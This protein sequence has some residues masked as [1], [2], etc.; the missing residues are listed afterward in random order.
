MVSHGQSYASNG[1]AIRTQAI[2]KALSGH[3]FEALCFVRPGRPWELGTDKGAVDTQEI[4][5]GVRYIHSRWPDDQ[6]PRGE[7]NTLKAS[8]ERFVELFRIYRPEAVLAAS[9]YI[10]GL[11]AWI[12]ARRLGLPFYNEVRGFWELSRAAREPGYE[13]T[14]AFNVEAARDAFVGRQALKVFTLNQPMKEELAR[15]GVDADKIEIV[16]NG[17]SKLPEIK[18]T[19][20]A[21]RQ[22]LE[23]EA[24]D[25][26]VGYVGSFT[27]Y[28]GL[29]VLLDAC[30]ELVNQGEKIK[31]L[32]VGDGQPVTK[33]SGS[34][35]TLVDKPWLIQVGRVPHEQVADYY[36]L[37]D[38]VVI[39][40]KKLPVCE[41]VPPM[42]AAEAL[43]YGK[44]LVVSDVAA[45]GGIAAKHEGVVTFDAGRADSLAF[46]IQKVLSTAA[47]S[48]STAL[49][50]QDSINS[51]AWA[52]P[53]ESS[54][55]TECNVAL[56]EAKVPTTKELPIAAPQ[57]KLKKAPK[58]FKA[59][60]IMDEISEECWKYE[61]NSFRVDR[62]NYKSQVKSSTATFAFLESCWKGNGGAWEYAFTSPG[63]KHA[64]AQ[65]L[66]DLIPRVKEKMPVVFWNKEDPM[67]YERYLPIAKQADIIFTT[68]SNK[69]SSYEQDVPSADVY[70]VPFAAQQQICNPSDRFRTEP[71]T[72]CFAGSYYGVGHDERKRQMDALLPSIL[73][74]NGAIYDRFSKI[75]SDRYKFPEKFQPFIRD[76]VPFHE[77][78]K[79]YKRFKV[80]LN[81]NTIV[82][83]PTMMSRRV[84]ELLAC[85]TPVVSTPS[86]AIEE[87]FS[88]IVHMANDAQE[89]NKI[90]ERLLTDEHYWERTSH[91]GYR[92]VMTRHTYVHR[93]QSIKQ[94]LGYEAEDEEP[95]VSIITCTRRPNM[96]DRIVENMTRQNHS[97][98]ELI[99]VL[100]DF[101]SAQKDDLLGKLKAK[102]SNLKRIEVIVN[103]SQ[104]ITL[105]ERFNHAATY[106]KGEYIAKMDDD[107]FYFENYLSDMLIPFKFGNYGMVGKQELYMYLSGSNKLIKRFP[108]MKHREV[109]FVAGPTFVIKKS[110]FDKIKFESRNTGED[111]TFIKNLKSA[112]YKIYAADP[113]NFIQYRGSGGAHTWKVDD[114]FFLN[115]K[116][117][118]VI[119]D[120]FAQA[121]VDF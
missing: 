114:D 103:D 120:G 45:L 107:D 13:N 102:S 5:D 117:T 33:V 32:W 4:V 36:A 113:F 69:V 81:V 79:L 99:L 75:D 23:I 112:G 52:L 35:K 95:L 48:A 108:S 24:D 41:L 16:P 90:I 64:N 106:A 19:F 51:L 97:N 1:Y 54:V 9:N 46:S 68:D 67:H 70:A 42:K 85:G 55:V 56:P 58:D 93:L 82:D 86:K 11:P 101:S 47:P 57:K 10:V 110:V 72:V 18:H 105:G 39:P 116:Q 62:K 6:H 8:V 104:D 44:R 50:M 96:I 118:Q 40:R 84:Y 83:S 20:P 7:L 87:Q 34:S 53:G 91:L 92:E 109:D 63:L 14:P 80:F 89:A 100:Q 25:K 119:S 3:G 88:G 71:E 98:C 17:V 111:S 74:F 73:D 94:A 38:I 65:A 28:E 31:L 37:I 27:P 43:A 59:I 66:L 76:A 115:G 15:R 22:R 2:A 21:L 60:S 29:D 78:V 26:V 121:Y 61:F 12:A 49:L 30:A 77:V